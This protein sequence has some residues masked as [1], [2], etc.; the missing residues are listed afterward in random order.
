MP[1]NVSE[2]CY[3]SLLCSTTSDMEDCPR[4]MRVLGQP[5]APLQSFDAELLPRLLSIA[6]DERPLIWVDSADVGT[7]RQ[8]VRFAESCD[9]TVHIG[10]STGTKIQKRI[11]ASEGWLGASLNEAALHADLVISLGDSLA[12][13]LPQL[14]KMLATPAGAAKTQL[15]IGST[16]STEFG[17]SIVLPREQWYAGISQL[18]HHLRDKHNAPAVSPQLA[19]LGNAIKASRYAVVAWQVDEFLDEIDE[20]LLRRLSELARF[21]SQSARLALL[22]I[23]PNPGRVTA[24]ETMLWATGFAPTAT[25]SNGSWH[26]RKDLLTAKLDEFQKA[27]SSILMLRTTCSGAPLPAI[28]ADLA[29][30]PQR[31]RKLA[32]ESVKHTFGVPSIGDKRSGLL[33]RGDN[34]LVLHCQ[35]TAPEEASPAA[36]DLLA[37]ASQ[38]MTA[39]QRDQVQGHAE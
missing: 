2:C 22:S 9:A 19:Q 23:D 12:A 29:L 15:H 14:A 3:C 27:H 13:E 34:S 20:L 36:A 1:P 6:K 11:A 5:Q 35:R 18:L 32:P 8:V 30:L 16:D 17:K 26:P 37:E 39:A 10:Q 7:M 33:F 4:R 38:A 28:A 31:E 24:H 21:R 25:F